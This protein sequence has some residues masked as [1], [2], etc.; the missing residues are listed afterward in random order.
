[1]RMES[2]S[3]TET[4]SNHNNDNKSS[5]FNRN[6]KDQ[7]VSASAVMAS[8]GRQRQKKQAA[9]N[10]ASPLLNLDELP[11]SDLNQLAKNAKS[12][13]KIL[14][15]VEQGVGADDGRQDQGRNQEGQGGSQH[16]NSLPDTLPL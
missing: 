12:L 4:V 9:E 5:Y 6:K 1:M 3:N 16:I 13:I 8:S 11:I 14:K 15:K 10:K 2:S 7:I